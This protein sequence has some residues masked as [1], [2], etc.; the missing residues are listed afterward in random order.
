MKLTF[1]GA[2]HEVTGSRTLLEWQDGHYALIDCGMEQG[3]DVFENAPMPIP[4]SQVEVVIL[5]HAH[6][7][8]TGNLPL[9]YKEGFR[10]KVYA[11]RETTMLCRI[12]LAD[13]AHIQMMEAAYANRK[14]ERA[15]GK[16]V[17]PAYTV[18]DVI[19]L[20]EHFVPCPYE[21]II[22][23]APGLDVRFTDMGHLLGS[24]AVSCM[25]EDQGVQKTMVFS[26]DVGNVDQPIINDPSTVEYADYLLIESTYGD[27]LHPKRE[28]PIPLLAKVIQRTLDRGGNVIIPSFA[29]GR[30]QEMLY[31]IRHIKYHGMVIGHDGF[32]VYVDSPLANE[33]TKI[34]LEAGESCLDEETRTLVRKGINPIDFEDL[35][36][37]V[38]AEDSKRLNDDMTPKVIISASGMCDAGRVRHHLKYNL[39]RPEST[40]LFVGYQA[41]GTL[42]RIL[43]DGA[44]TVR[45]FGDEIAVRAEI[46]SLQGVSGHGDQAGLLAWIKG[47]KTPPPVMFVNHGEDQVSVFFAE[48]LK[49]QFGVDAFAPFSGSVFNLLTGQWEKLT[50]GELVQAED[51]ANQPSA[52]R[53]RTKA[54][55]RKQQVYQAFLDAAQRLM[56]VA[57][58]SEGLANRELNRLTDRI[59]QL[60]HDIRN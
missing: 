12:M 6:I 50:E 14:A 34:F 10:G 39:W 16:E 21:E 8:H 58:G 7:D 41:N 26:G 20:M 55:I 32:P 46:A 43:Y 33:A 37:S 29:V 18:D 60:I 15:G 23:V 45:L 31:F 27:R 24:A 52:S 1:L 13:S 35:Q 48:L 30:T 54:A 49:E 28:D 9:L 42:G 36:A 11:T 3:N 19:A 40:V 44:E 22:P 5:T 2:N 17:T 4:A 51:G 25:M 47:F 53:G 57:K 38:S 59:N 56:E